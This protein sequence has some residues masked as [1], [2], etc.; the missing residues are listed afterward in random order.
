MLMRKIERFL[1][2]TGMPVVV[3]AIQCGGSLEHA[4]GVFVPAL[5]VILSAEKGEEFGHPLR[6]AQRNRERY[7][8][9]EGGMYLLRCHVVDLA[10]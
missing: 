9:V 4:A 5:V 2:Q 8:S 7:L 3:G 10:G 6:C 1:A